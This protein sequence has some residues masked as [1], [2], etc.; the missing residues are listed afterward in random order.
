[1][2]QIN[3]KQYLAIMISEV[4]RLGEDPK[5]LSGT[6]IDISDSN[7]TVE[8]AVS[9]ARKVVKAHQKKEGKQQ[10]SFEEQMKRQI[11]QEMEYMPK[12]LRK[13]PV[14]EEQKAKSPFYQIPTINSAMRRIL[15]GVNTIHIL[16]KEIQNSSSDPK[17]LFA[18]ARVNGV[19]KADLS[20]LCLL[21]KYRCPEDIRKYGLEGSQVDEVIASILK[22][23][24][25]LTY[26]IDLLINN[27]IDN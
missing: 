22:Y 19:F 2:E 8:G 16:L 9:T 6:Q 20:V 7:M 4:K 5:I 23:G 25:D 18:M 10:T 3:L 24:M 21:Q 15:Q 1:M 12:R 11:Q 26:N 13:D 27:Y 17:L 14:E